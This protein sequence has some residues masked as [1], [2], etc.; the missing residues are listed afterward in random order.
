MNI[1]CSICGLDHTTVKL[2]T[3]RAMTQ[4]KLNSQAGDEITVCE[5]CKKELLKGNHPLN[6]PQETPPDQGGFVKPSNPQ[7]DKPAI[8]PQ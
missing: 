3:V 4:A 6:A 5:H 7:G 1:L 2:T 8:R